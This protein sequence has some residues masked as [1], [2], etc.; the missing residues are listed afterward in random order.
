MLSELS[1]GRSLA[2]GVVYCCIWYSVHRSLCSPFGCCNYWVPKKDKQ[3][4]AAVISSLAKLRTKYRASRENE[5][6]TIDTAAIL[7]KAE[8]DVVDS[9]MRRRRDAGKNNLLLKWYGKLFL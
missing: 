2:G 1:A 6:S 5:L 4:P 7:V 3:G 8:R 9:I